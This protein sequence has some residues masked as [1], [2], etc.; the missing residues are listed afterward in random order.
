[1]DELETEQ[2]ED[3]K[4]GIEKYRKINGEGEERKKGEW[5]L[6]EI[7]NSGLREGTLGT[8]SKGMN[9]WI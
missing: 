9:L 7:N 8:Q 4:K 5:C 2:E 6:K 1:M 3:E